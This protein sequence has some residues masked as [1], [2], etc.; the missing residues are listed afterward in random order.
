MNIPPTLTVLAGPNGAGKSYF[1]NY[2]K[3]QEL[4]YSQPIN[5]DALK[6]EINYTFISNDYMRWELEENRAVN[7]LFLSLCKEA[8]E[9]KKHF[10]FECNLRKDQL[11]CVELFDKA[12]YQLNLI[13]F[14]LD[15]I[16]I[17]RERVQIRHNEGGHPVGE[18]SIR[19]NFSE[20]CRNLDYSVPDNHWNQVIFIDN[21]R[22]NRASGEIL[23]LLLL[24][25]QGKLIYCSDRFFSKER[26]QYLPKLCK[27]I[28]K[29]QKES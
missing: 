28:R 29:Q 10:A 18:E 23:S 3:E 16:E 11:G 2:L 13:F 26:E 22:E 14:W 12:G 6:E 27:W 17:S 24:I 9:E 4:L 15:S 1:S 7:R 20:G 25:N 21:S 8:I 19:G 5:M